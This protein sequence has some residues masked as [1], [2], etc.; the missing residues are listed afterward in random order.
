MVK[1][2]KKRQSQREKIDREHLY[3]PGEALELV[4]E[5]A[6]AKFDETVELAMRL[7]VNPKHAEQQ[8]R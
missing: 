2:S 3:E 4:K 5:T 8:V 6:S 7:N 1:I